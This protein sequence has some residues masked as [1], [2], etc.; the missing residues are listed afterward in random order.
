MRQATTPSI[1]QFLLCCAWLL[2]KFHSLHHTEK[3]AL[4]DQGL[5]GGIPAEMWCTRRSAPAGKA[6]RKNIS[7]IWHWNLEVEKILWL[8]PLGKVLSYHTSCYSGFLLSSP[9]PRTFLHF[10]TQR[11]VWKC[12]GPIITGLAILKFLDVASLRC[13][14]HFP[15][16]PLVA[17]FV[18]VHLSFN[19]ITIA[20]WYPFLMLQDA[21]KKLFFAL[22]SN[23]WFLQPESWKRKFGMLEF[24]MCFF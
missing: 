20:T 13:W 10:S 6:C 8:I 21:S 18:F 11:I 17:A 14:Y 22:W 15:Q 7:G 1:I 3:L 19:L 2:L 4:F 5:I 23:W 12:R 24:E 16:L 9:S